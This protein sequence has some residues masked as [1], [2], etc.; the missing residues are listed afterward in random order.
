M[1]QGHASDGGLFFTNGELSRKIYSHKSL[2]RI[3]LKAKGSAYKGSYP[4]M[5]VKI[6]G[7]LK[8]EY[9][10]D[11]E[12]YADYYTDLKLRPGGHTLSLEYVNDLCGAGP[13]PEDRN[14]WVDRLSP[15]EF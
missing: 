15:A 8:D 13:Q 10:V 4:A 2:V 12:N 14:V 7:K 11:S 9:Y 6:D 5:Y 3:V 1:D